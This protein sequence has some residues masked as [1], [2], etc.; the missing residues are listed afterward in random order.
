MRMLLKASM[1][2]EPGN[3]SA[4]DGPMG[5]TIQQILG[6]AKLT[7]SPAMNARDLAA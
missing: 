5:K 7:F 2:V 3:R 1:P 4:N 6:D